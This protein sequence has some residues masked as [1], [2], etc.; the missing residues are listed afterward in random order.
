MPI[1]LV[2]AENIN[3]WL[4]RELSSNPFPSFTAHVD[5]TRKHHRIGIDAGQ[6]QMT[7]FQMQ[8]TEDM[9]SHIPLSCILRRHSRLNAVE[10]ATVCDPIIPL[11]PGRASRRRF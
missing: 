2:I 3:D 11:L 7:E 6:F 9:Q 5:I 1:E 10:M 4:V 8:I